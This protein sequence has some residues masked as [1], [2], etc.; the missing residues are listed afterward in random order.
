MCLTQKWGHLLH[1]P[2]H[3]HHPRRRRDQ[4]MGIQQLLLQNRRYYLVQQF[5]SQQKLTVF[6]RLLHLNHHL[7][8]HS[9]SC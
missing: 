6:L 9:S 3:L 5:L 8:R 2:L 1:R 7:L 4:Q